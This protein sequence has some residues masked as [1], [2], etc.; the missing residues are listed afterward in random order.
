MSGFKDQ[1]KRDILDVFHNADEFAEAAEIEYNGRVYNDIPI[2]VDS[3][4]AKE[5]AKASGDN[6][7]GV[8]A[9]DLTVFVSFEDLEIVPRKETPIT[10]DGV[11]Y[12]I[13][14]VA[15]NAG[16]I[17]LDLEMLDE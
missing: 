13:V 7:E 16:E 15:F 5:R 10:I 12:S 9:V 3:D 2:V 17:T 14:N 4:V 1:L 11:E 6:S 8:Y